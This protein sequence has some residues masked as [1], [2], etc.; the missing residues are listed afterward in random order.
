MKENPSDQRKRVAA[1]ILRQSDA[2]HAIQSGVKGEIAYENLKNVP[3]DLRSSGPKHLRTGVNM[4]MCNVAA[5]ARVLI[6][7]GI[8]TEVEYHEALADLLEAEKATYETKLSGIY[9]TKVT[10]G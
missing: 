6:A 3:H 9:G 1:A 4:A 5:V 7:K 10:L 2:M 8:I